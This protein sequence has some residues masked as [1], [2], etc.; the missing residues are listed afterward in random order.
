MR[1]FANPC[2]H[3]EQ[4]GDRVSTIVRILNSRY[5]LRSVRVGEASNPGPGSKRRRSLRLRAL[6]RSMDSDSE[7]SSDEQPLMQSTSVPPDVLSALE[8]D[9]C[10]SR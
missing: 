3:G 9:L 5:G 6:Q 7:S 2:V 4:H 8:H 1:A 10:G